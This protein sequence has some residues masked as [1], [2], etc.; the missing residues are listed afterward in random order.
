MKLFLACWTV[1][2]ITVD[3]KQNQMWW[4]L[5]LLHDCL[6]LCKPISSCECTKG[7]HHVLHARVSTIRS[8]QE[9]PFCSAGPSDIHIHWLING[10]SVDTPVMEYRRPLGQREVLVSSWLRGGPLIKEARYRCVAE[11]STGSD[12]SDIDLH[13]TTGGI[14]VV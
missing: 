8:Q 4:N 10:Y 5:L 12:T 3:T 7:K 14:M 11:A 13:L 6:H 2:M 9:V 1:S